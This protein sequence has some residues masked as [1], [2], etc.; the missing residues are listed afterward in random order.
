MKNLMSRILGKL[1]MWCDSSIG[2]NANEVFNSIRINAL[3][4]QL[5]DNGYISKNRYEKDIT[6]QIYSIL[7]GSS[8][9]GG[10]R[11]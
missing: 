9:G 8:N 1:F 4:S 10:E 6:K 5:Q 3:I 7:G 2:R 11:I